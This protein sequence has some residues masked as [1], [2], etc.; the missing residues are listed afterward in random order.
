[1]DCKNNLSKMIRM[2]LI[3]LFIGASL[4]IQLSVISVDSHAHSLKT[5]FRIESF[6]RSLETSGI[7]GQS[8]IYQ[9]RGRNLADQNGQQNGRPA[10]QRH[11][12][13]TSS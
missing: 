6:V 11:L 1:M 12:S 2:T 9:F 4:Q 13:V 7:D 8:R 5:A 10:T 3:L